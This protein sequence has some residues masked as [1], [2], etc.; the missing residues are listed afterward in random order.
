M[1]SVVL[2]AAMAAAPDAP[3]AL[4]CPV[5]Q[6][7]YGH[8]FWLK[9]CFY[10]CCAPAR[11]GWV[12]C[13]SK[14]YGVYPTGG[15]C[16]LGFYNPGACSCAPCGGGYAVGAACRSGKAAPCWG[17]YEWGIGNQPAYYTGVTGCPP[18]VTAP[19]Y[20][21]YTQKNPCCTNGHFAFDSGLIGHSHGVGYAG[22]SGFGNFG[23]YGAVPMGHP[24]T[25][26]DLPP[27]PRNWTYVLPTAP[28]GGVPMPPIPGTAGPKP[29]EPPPAGK[30]EPKPDPTPKSPPDSLLPKP[31]TVPPMPEAP[32]VEPKPEAKPKLGADRPEPATVVLSV[33]A[34]ATVTVEGQALRSTGR[35]RTFRTPALAPG[36]DFVYQVRAVLTV[37]GAEE[38]EVKEVTVTAGLTSRAS[39]ERLFAKVEGRAPALANGQ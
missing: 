4:L 24:A 7:R 34:G 29:F 30:V 36:Q 15:R 10:D 2:M 28:P 25:T 38:V 35:E 3:Q 27:F 37:G 1:Y 32:K 18:H 13:W 16:G 12:N 5:N 9:H 22:F 26:A 33:P 6:S 19:P 20:A 31:P 11:Y 39:F 8:G 23:F 17:Q 14:G 21:Y